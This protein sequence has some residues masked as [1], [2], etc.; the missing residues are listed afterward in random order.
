MLSAFF[1]AANTNAQTPGVSS[2]VCTD[3]VNLAPLSQEL[4]SGVNDKSPVA[5][6]QTLEQV[7]ARAYPEVQSKDLRLRTFHSKSDY[8]RTRFSLPRFFFFLPMRYFV[9][10]NPELFTRGAPADGVCAILGHEMAHV[11]DLSH[12][13]RIRL[14]RLIKLLS[15]GYTIRFERRADLEA[16][17]RG[18]GPELIAYRN[19]VYNNIPPAKVPEKKRNYFSPPEITVILELTRTNRQLFDEWKRTVPLNQAEIE[20]SATEKNR[21]KP[22]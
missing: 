17:R 6:R 5:V 22:D 16:I 9:E 12:G 3:N 7:E 20:A 10:V 1:A 14:F 11:A 13:N 19:W 18:F 15:S 21:R 8:F 2:A 4:A